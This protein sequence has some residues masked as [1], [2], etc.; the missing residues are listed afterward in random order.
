MPFDIVD[1]ETLLNRL[2][3][4]SCIN[5]SVTEWPYLNCIGNTAVNDKNIE[6][7]LWKETA[8]SFSKLSFYCPRIA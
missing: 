3:N 7:G 1:K 4:Y 8:M 6:K 5:S 2:R